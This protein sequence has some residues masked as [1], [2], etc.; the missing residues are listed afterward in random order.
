MHR[1]AGRSSGHL[2]RFAN[3]VEVERAAPIII[4]QVEDG[5]DNRA[6]HLDPQLPHPLMKL[7]AIDGPILAA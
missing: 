6:L 1:G 2:E 4:E 5:I 3:L 7:L